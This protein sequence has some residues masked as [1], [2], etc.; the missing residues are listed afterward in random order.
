MTGGRQ[1]VVWDGTVSGL[2]DVLYDVRQGLILGPLLFIIL[3]SSMADFLGVREDETMV[4]ADDANV[5]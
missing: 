2:V 3:T 5:W 4:Y 1:S